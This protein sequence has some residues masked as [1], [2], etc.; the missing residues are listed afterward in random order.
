MPLGLRVSVDQDF[1]VSSRPPFEGDGCPVVCDLLAAHQIIGYASA[2]GAHYMCPLCDLD[3]DD[4]HILDHDKWPAKDVAEVRKFA[5]LWKEASSSSDKDKLFQA[6]GWRWSPLFELPYFDPTV[7]TVVD[8][9]HAIDVGLLKFHCRDVF[10]IDLGN[11]GGDGSIAGPVGLR[12]AVTAQ[13]E[14]DRQRCIK[15]LRKNPPELLFKLLRYDRRILYYICDM[16][17]IKTLG[18]DIIVGNTVGF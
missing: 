4:I 10:Q 16:Y 2:P 17:E 13:E 3:K 15:L 9:M 14:A 12:E 7:F 8:A 18:Y 1:Q 6:F 5:F 11:H